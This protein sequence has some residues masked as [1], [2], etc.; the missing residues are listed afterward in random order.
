MRVYVCV[1]LQQT[2]EVFYKPF[3]SRPLCWISHFQMNLIS[4]FKVIFLLILFFDHA[5][6]KGGNC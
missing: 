1:F 6:S 3:P 4:I 5:R 2:A